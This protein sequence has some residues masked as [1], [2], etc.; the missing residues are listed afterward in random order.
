[1]D[2]ASAIRRELQRICASAAFRNSRRSR[3]FLEYIVEKTLAGRVDEL[4]ERIIGSSLYGRPADYDTG[5]DSM[6]RVVANET[7]RRLQTY[8]AQ[9]ENDGPVRIEL[10]AGSY[11]PAVHYRPPATDA[12][13]LKVVPPEP[14]LRQAARPRWS[15]LSKPRIWMTATLVLAGFC[16]F[17]LVQNRSLRRQVG[18]P[19][20]TSAARVTEPWSTLFTGSR[21]LQVLLA[22]TSVGG[23]QNLLKTQLPLA[24]YVN[25]RYIPEENRIAPELDR[26]LQFL[27]ASQYTSASYATT[28]VRIAQFAQ[29]FS[30]PVTVSYARDMSLRTF[31]SGEN[32]I[33]LG[34]TRANPWAQL[35]DSRLNFSVSFRNARSEQE[36]LFRNRAPRAGEPSLYVPR[37]SL[38][39]TTGE[40]YGHIAFLPFFYKGGNMLLLTGTDSAATEAAGEFVTNVERLRGA[41]IKLGCDPSGAPRSFELLL[42]VRNTS[43]TPF[44]SEVIAGRLHSASERDGEMALNSVGK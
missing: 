13:D 3:V 34:T 31:K 6:V 11:L 8:Y 36:V 2:N 41:L 40:S 16:I 42:L 9:P 27:L 1:M 18:D 15:A 4:K 20:P 32:F 33:V 43:G 7:R 17:L 26:F 19:T 37:A 39:G 14:E 10:C 44:Q 22:D 23:I 24:E 35:F 29:S 5:T 28:A 21:G 25:R 30:I 12:Q 38:S